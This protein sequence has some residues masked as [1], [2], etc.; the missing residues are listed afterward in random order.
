MALKDQN[1]KAILSRRV[2]EKDFVPSQFPQADPVEYGPREDYK[3]E[4]R[5]K[6]SPQARLFL[7]RIKL[8]QIAEKSLY[9]KL[10]IPGNPAK[11]IFPRM[12]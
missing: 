9:Q 2:L 6:V 8:T 4:H 7:K 3:N 11:Y 1:Q 10:A 5:T 12:R